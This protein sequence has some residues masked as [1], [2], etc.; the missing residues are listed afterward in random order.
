MRKFCGWVLENYAAK[1]WEAMRTYPQRL[2]PAWVHVGN[3]RVFCTVSTH[4]VPG[5]SHRNFL[6]SA[7]V[8]RTVLPTIHITN[9][10]KEFLNN[11]FIINRS[12]A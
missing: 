4:I 10:N 11:F 9:K 8:R 1:L 5:L 12:I 7:P 6:I 2:Q 3:P